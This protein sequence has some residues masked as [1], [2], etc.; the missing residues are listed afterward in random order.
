MVFDQKREEDLSPSLPNRAWARPLC[1][2][3]FWSGSGSSVRTGFFV[4]KRM[5]DSQELLRYLLADLGIDAT[6]KDVVWMHE[7]LQKI[8][9]SEVTA[10]KQVVLFI[11]EAQNLSESVLETIRLISDFETPQSKLIQIVFSGQPQLA[12]RLA[13]PAL[14]Q[15]RQRIS[16]L[17]RG[18]PIYTG[19]DRR[20][21]QPQAAGRRA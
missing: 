2:F 1:C 3:T 19:G 10:G 13:S 14:I 21:Y 16:I 15:L 7:E 12:D 18:A 20:V 11:D 8:L 9:I 4:L 5:C 6:G 17:S